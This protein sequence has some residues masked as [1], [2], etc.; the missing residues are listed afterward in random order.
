MKDPWQVRGSLC[1]IAGHAEE[2]I[3]RQ[4]TLGFVGPLA[5]EILQGKAKDQV[6]LLTVQNLQAGSTPQPYS[7]HRNV[8]QVRRLIVS[9]LAMDLDP[10]R[11]NAPGH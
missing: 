11:R 4:A 10:A 5:E 3:S 9:V 2:L 7:L 8:K 1:L 6:R